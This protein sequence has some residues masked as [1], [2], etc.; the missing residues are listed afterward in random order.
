[1]RRNG[2]LTSSASNAP[3]WDTM[4]PCVPTRL[5][6]RPHFQRRKQEDQKG[7]VVVAMRRD[8]KL[9]HVLTKRMVFAHH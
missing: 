1:V 6:T 9:H 7:S 8:M 5:M 3:I 4:H 2:W